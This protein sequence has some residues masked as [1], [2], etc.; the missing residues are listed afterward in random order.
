MPI[1][2]WG[3]YGISLY[4]TRMTSM[5]AIAIWI[6]FLKRQQRLKSQET[7]ADPDRRIRWVPESRSPKT[8]NTH[9]P[10]TVDLPKKNNAVRWKKKYRR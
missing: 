3:D 8:A 5:S 2:G 10:K 9:Q 1:E 4:P 7:S 6:D